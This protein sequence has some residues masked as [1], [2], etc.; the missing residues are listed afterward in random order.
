MRERMYFD[1]SPIAYK[2]I[3]ES[4]ILRQREKDMFVDF[5]EGMSMNELTKKYKYC[6]RTIWTRK[7]EIYEKTKCLCYYTPNMGDIN[8]YYAENKTILREYNDD[9]KIVNID[10]DLYKVYLLTF[11][12]NKV[13]VG[14][15]S[16]AEKT[17]WS[18]GNG[19]NQNE[20]MYADILKYG[21]ANIK[22]NILYK[23]LLF[24]E[25]REKEK[26]LIIH[27]RIHLKKYGYNKNF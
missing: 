2:F 11:P 21:W 5:V 1:F 6:E 27:Y 9:L 20:N 12:N 10:N 16:N 3:L 17:R 19:Y 14:I 15:T 7:K 22:K 23:D 26:E 4:N 13:Y 24:D 8:T 18:N 25:A